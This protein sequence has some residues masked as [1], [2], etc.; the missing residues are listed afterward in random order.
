MVYVWT[1]DETRALPADVLSEFAGRGS[2]FAAGSANQGKKQ[3]I[4]G[5]EYDYVF[6][7]QLSEGAAPLKLGYNAGDNP[8]MAAQEFIHQNELQQD[9]LD[10]IAKFIIANTSKV[11]LGQQR[12]PEIDPFSQDR[13][14]P[15]GSVAA[16]QAQPQSSSAFFPQKYPIFMDQGNFAPIIT[17]VQQLNQQF[18]EDADSARQS[19]ALAG[20]E[21]QA[22]ES[23]MNTLKD[24]SRYHSSNFSAAEIAAFKKV[25][26]TWPSDQ[27]FPVLD[28][29][30]L[31]AIHPEFGP[32]FA[33]QLVNIAQ[34][35]IRSDAPGPCQIMATRF[36]AN[37]FKFDSLK[38]ILQSQSKSILERIAD[39]ASS[40]NKNVRSAVSTVL[41]N[42]SILFGSNSSSS[43]SDAKTQVLSILSALMS[44]E[45]DPEALFIQLVALGTLISTDANIRKT[46]SELGL[47]SVVSSTSSSPV[48]K[49]KDV[50]AELLKVMNK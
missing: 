35:N 30:R 12:G 29:L 9:F 41:L 45:S 5:K 39:L 38:T 42:Y 14:R 6:D 47:S 23:A 3:K 37:C 22:F 43:S 11:E 18:A 27:R 20:A 2:A 21:L 50:G 16:P 10:E 13:Y 4:A 44:S 40:T 28:L 17:K 1:R 19:F 33:D 34:N 24:T 8:Y 26:T 31:G 15:Q 32:K 25:V 49:V 7:V 36:V 46:A 48:Q